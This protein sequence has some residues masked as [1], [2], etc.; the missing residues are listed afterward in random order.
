MPSP[1]P[2]F[3]SAILRNDMRAIRELLDRSPDLISYRFRQAKLYRSGL[4]HWLYVGDS[5]L[6]LAAAAHMP[7][8]TRCLIESGADP[9]AAASSR[10]G[11][12]VHY[13]SDGCVAEPGYDRA[14]QVETLQILLE[15]GGRVDAQDANGATPLHRAVRTRCDGAVA[16][17]LDAGA[18]PEA[19][20]HAGSTSFH[21][22]VQSTGRG[23]SGSEAAI[24]AQKRILQSFMKRQVSVELRCGKERTVAEWA[25]RTWVGEYLHQLRTR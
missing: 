11:T 19:R 21:L 8:V 13:A 9:N 23:G 12:P 16:L 5:W 7:A 17:L 22:A 6:H 3:E 25:R 1:H 18:D 15:Q 20:N 4:V 14:R 2:L 10:R 24:A